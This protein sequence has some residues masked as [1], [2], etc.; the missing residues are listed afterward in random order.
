[1]K[2]SLVDRLKLNRERIGEMAKGIRQVAALRSPLGE[3]VYSYHKDNG[4]Y[5]EE[6]R[7]PFGVIGIIYESRPNVTADA[8]ALCFQ[9]ANAVILRGGSDA[10]HSNRA[11]V[12]RDP[13]RA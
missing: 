6:R 4:L 13:G 8:F 10:I 12:S 2:G 3:C 1:M 7:V 5:I 11:I 9:T